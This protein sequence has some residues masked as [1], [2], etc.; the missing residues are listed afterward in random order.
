MKGLSRLLLLAMLVLSLGL[1]VGC[2]GDDGDDGAAGAAGAAGASAY[3]IA[4]ANGFTGTEAEWLASLE[5]A[6]PAGNYVGLVN[7]STCHGTST[8]V[9]GWVKSKH[10]MNS[11][12]SVDTCSTACH[13]PLGDMADMETAFGVAPSGTVVGCESCHGPGS[14]HV[15]VGPI[16]TPA[17]R[18]DVCGKCHTDIDA[19]GHLSHH[20]FADQIAERFVTSRHAV[21]HARTEFCSACHSHEGGVALLGMGRQ[22]SLSDLEDVYNEASVGDIWMLPEGS[23]TIFG[24]TTKTCAT[25]HDAHETE[26]RGDGDITAKMLGYATSSTTQEA[27]VVY[28]A[29]FNLCTSCHMV[30]LDVNPAPTTDNHTVTDGVGNNGRLVFEYTLSD[31]YSAANL[32]DATSG[33]YDFTKKVFY[34]DGASGNGRTMID[35]HFGGQILSHLVDF[36]GGNTDITIKGYNVYPGAASACT[37]CHDPHTAGK[38]LS[39]DSSSTI[40]YADQL[41]NQAVS[42]AEGLGDFHNSAQTTAAYRQ[43]GCAPCHSGDQF[44]ATTYGVAPSEAWDWK[45]IGCRACHDLAVANE[46]PAA[47]NSAAFAEVR[48]FLENKEFKFNSGAIATVADLGVNQICFDCHKGREAVKA[49]AGT[50]TNVYDVSYLHYAPSMAILFGND[51]KM[52]PTYAGKSYAGRFTHYDG[53]KFGCVDCHDVHNTEGNHV[54]HNK[55]Q[56]P[57]FDC[58]GCHQTGAFVDAAGLQARTVA[59]GERLRATIIATYNNR[60]DPD[61]DE[62]QFHEIMA[63]RGAASNMKANDLAFATSVYKG[64]NYEDGSPHGTEHG[65]GGSWAHNSRFAR[66]AQYDAI[67]SLGGDL[68]GLVRP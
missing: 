53:E 65:H 48:T 40:D 1:L 42:Y 18:E 35:T 68:T 25:C 31:A 51:S 22:T 20:P 7:C 27:T 55:M 4:K 2:E 43:N 37:T 9:A 50:T 33:T 58:N 28:S 6:P 36:Q 45:T 26:L 60:F 41:D 54:V 59:Y 62:D 57:A 67:Q 38:L 5:A 64:F 52:V 23:D 49:T 39:I 46:V 14:G 30:E 29:E 12:H 13:N 32:V 10:A 19:V 17:P 66:Q 44:A 11:D 21:Q 15:G 56:N 24:V 34:H 63:A 16:P 8:A 61:I 3:E 47:N